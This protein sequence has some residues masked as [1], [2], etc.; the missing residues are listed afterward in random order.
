[1]K[2]FVLIFCASFFVIT[3][4]FA[5]IMI[6]LDFTNGS[7]S[8]A[9]IIGASFFSAWCFYKEYARQATKHEA[10]TFALFSVM[11]IWIISFVIAIPFLAFMFPTN[12]LSQ[13]LSVITSKFFIISL[14][15]GGLILSL[16]YYL[17][18]RWAFSWFTKQL[19]KKAISA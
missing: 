8:I 17:A 7:F 13:L 18:I 19:E 6:A 9:T 11:G 1:M 2:K 12:G 10:K 14:T 16:I 15:V 3:L 4:A 5:G